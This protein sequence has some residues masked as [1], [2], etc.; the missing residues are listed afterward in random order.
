MMA[1]KEVLDDLEALGDW[2]SPMKPYP[3]VPTLAVGRDRV[4]T[5]DCLVP[6]PFQ[7]GPLQP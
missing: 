2:A 3:S 6:V 1:R 4:T 7:R 5:A